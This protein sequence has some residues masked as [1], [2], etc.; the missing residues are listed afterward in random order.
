[1]ERKFDPWPPSSHQPHPST[2][3][4]EG[5]AYYWRHREDN[6]VLITQGVNYVR[7]CAAAYIRRT[8]ADR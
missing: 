2:L 7:A 5:L 6:W 3:S 4:T 1:M 8:R